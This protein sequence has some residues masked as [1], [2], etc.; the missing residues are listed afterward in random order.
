MPAQA[1]EEDPDLE[2]EEEEKIEEDSCAFL[3]NSD[4]ENSEPRKKLFYNRL[5]VPF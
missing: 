3:D 4:F 1:G 2:R 5:S